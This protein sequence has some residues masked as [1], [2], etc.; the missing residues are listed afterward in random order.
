MISKADAFVGSDRD[1][2]ASG[3][4]NK[5]L[6]KRSFIIASPLKKLLTFTT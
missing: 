4:A 2:I 5:A 1:V 6:V 3:R